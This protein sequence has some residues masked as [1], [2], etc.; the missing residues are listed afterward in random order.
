MA[1]RTEQETRHGLPPREVKARST[2]AKHSFGAEMAAEPD[3]AAQALR[4]RVAMA[5][6][7]GGRA[8]RAWF[9][10]GL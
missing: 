1:N 6:R 8:R 10:V 7:L 9:L 4:V 2:S 3:R 5:P